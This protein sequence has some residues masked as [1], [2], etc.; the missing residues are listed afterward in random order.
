M[1]E[2]T[3]YKGRLAT[4]DKVRDAWRV[5]WHENTDGDVALDALELLE[6]GDDARA[7]ALVN[8]ATREEVLLFCALATDETIELERDATDIWERLS[9]LGLERE[10]D[11]PT[12]WEENDAQENTGAFWQ[13]LTQEGDDNGGR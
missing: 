5:F 7:A 9:A 8:L 4:P 11:E 1:A 10:E 2:L 6:E 13:G 12:F 3:I